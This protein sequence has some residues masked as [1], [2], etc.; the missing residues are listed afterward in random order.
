[1]AGRSHA[2]PASP[3]HLHEKAWADVYELTDLQLCP[4]GLR[5]IDALGLKPMDTV[6]DIGCGAGQT[7]LQLADRVGVE[8]RVIGVDVAPLLIQIAKRRTERLSQVSLIEAD[9]QA[10]DLP[11]C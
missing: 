6:L 4:L 10:L 8:G 2:N 5:A 1:M 11:P 9:A 7:L 3:K